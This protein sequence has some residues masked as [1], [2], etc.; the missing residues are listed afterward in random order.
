MLAQILPCSIIS[1]L[2]YQNNSLFS[3]P[4]TLSIFIRDPPEMVDRPTIQDGPITYEILGGHD[5]LIVAGCAADLTDLVIPPS[6]IHED[7][8]LPVIEIKKQ[9]FEG[10]RSLQSVALPETVTK[11]GGAAFE[12]IATLTSVTFAAGSRLTHIGPGAFTCDKALSSITIPR[13]VRE[14]QAWAFKDCEN[15]SAV[16]IEAPSALLI[17]GDSCFE[18]DR[19]E[20]FVL[21]P[22]VTEIQ[23][24]AFHQNRT[25]THFVVDEKSELK[26][27]GSGAFCETDLR[28]FHL[29]FSPKQPEHGTRNTKWA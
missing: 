7:K 15:L 29:P 20:A 17:I 2:I 28:F 21:P 11:I 19:L 10:H 3:I 5:G 13:S 23:D 14:I 1:Y 26:V 16:T 25:L 4:F 6:V 9:A 27:I 8:P 22:S 12:S 18:G 24:R